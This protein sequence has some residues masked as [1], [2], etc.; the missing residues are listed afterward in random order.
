MA[1]IKVKKTGLY[2]GSFNPI[3]LG[4]LI[5]ANYLIEFSDLDE[6]WLVVSPKNPLKEKRTL[7][8]D[9]YR[10]ELVKIAIEDYPKLRVTDIEFKLPKPSYTIDTLTVLSEKFPQK[11][12]SVI[13]GADSLQTINKWKN[14]YILMNQY[15]LYV[16]PRPGFDGGE[17][18]YHPNIKWVQAP[19]I[20]ISGSFIR[21]AIRQGK[22]P[23]FMLTP[24]VAE[25]IKEMHFYET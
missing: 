23:D 17:F 3:H 16:Y 9:H 2:F 4:H 10:L 21:D 13:M 7:L 18:K 15:M 5:I 8:C 11:Q 22:N 25:Y 6:V 14:Y 1:G 12:F 24:K 19:M 20:E